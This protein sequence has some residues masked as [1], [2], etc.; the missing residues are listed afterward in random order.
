[1]AVA[2]TQIVPNPGAVPVTPG[3]GEF[4]HFKLT[5]GGPIAIF[6]FASSAKGA[7]VEAADFPTH[8]TAVYEWNHLKNPSD[9]QQLEVLSLGLAFLTNANYQ[10]TVELRHAAGARTVLDITYSG[11]PADVF[12]ESFTV[13]IQ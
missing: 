2:R 3:A 10:Y 12:T 1:M 13:V 11:A 6:S 9:I 8:P 4:L 7:L 5:V